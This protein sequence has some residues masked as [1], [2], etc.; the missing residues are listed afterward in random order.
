M[1]YTKTVINDSLAYHTYFVTFEGE[2]KSI[3]GA[4]S[5]RGP[6]PTMISTSA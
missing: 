5:R 6:T 2:S 1:T 4:P 3:K